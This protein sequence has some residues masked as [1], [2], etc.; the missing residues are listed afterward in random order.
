MSCCLENRLYFWIYRPHNLLCKYYMVCLFDDHGVDNVKTVTMSQWKSNPRI[1]IVHGAGGYENEDS[2]V[3]IVA[4]P[5]LGCRDCKQLRDDYYSDS[6][7]CKLCSSNR[8][9]WLKIGRKRKTN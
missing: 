5:N 9:Q 1:L 3:T 6:F 8:L 7:D 4:V 2:Y